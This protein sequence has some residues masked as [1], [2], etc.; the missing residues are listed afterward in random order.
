MTMRKIIEKPHTQH[1]REETEIGNRSK[2]VTKQGKKAVGRSRE[3]AT[4]HSIE[5]TNICNCMQ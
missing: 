3:R 5:V 2:S 4:D 1:V